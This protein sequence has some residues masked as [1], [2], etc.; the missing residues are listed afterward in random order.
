MSQSY[1]DPVPHRTLKNSLVSA[2]RR[3]TQPKRRSV[4][5]LEQRRLLAT[6]TVT[7]AAD[8]GTGSLRAAIDLAYNN[9]GADTINFANALGGQTIS[10]TTAGSDRFGYAALAVFDQQLTIDGQTSNGNVTIA[11]GAT[12]PLMRLITVYNA[13]T[14]SLTL[15]NLTLT[16][17]S[18]KG[19]DG[20]GNGGGG[21]GVG[22]AIWNSAPLT[23]QNSTISGN[24][25]KGGQGGKISSTDSQPALTG[26]GGG[27]GMTGDG[28]YERGGGPDGGFAGNYG[29][30]QAGQT[31]GFG[32]GG[33]GG[34]NVFG[35]TSAGPGGVG[36]FLG[37]AGGP[38]RAP[39]NLAPDGSSGGFG[40]GGSAGTPASRSSTGGFGGFGGGDGD[41]NV[42][43][44]FTTLT[45]YGGAGAGFGGAIFTYATNLTVEN[46]AIVNNSAAGGDKLAITGNYND[47]TPGDGMGGGIFNYGGNVTIQNSTFSGNRAS[48]G[49]GSANSASRGAGGG[50]IN[51]NG[52][53]TLTHV[54]L[55]SNV[56]EGVGTNSSNFSRDGDAIYNLG[57]GGSAVVNIRNSILSS[58]PSNIFAAGAFASVAT[59][60]GSVSHSA[61]GSF[62]TATNVTVAGLT[63]SAS[64]T[65]S[66]LGDYGGPTQSIR[67]TGTNPAINGGTSG[68]G[69]IVDQRGVARPQF[70]APDAGAVEQNPADIG[71]PVINTAGILWY[72]GPDAVGPNLRVYREAGGQP[73]EWI[74]G[75][76]AIRIGQAVDGTVLV[77]NANFDVFAINGSRTGTFVNY[78]LL[79]SAKSAGDTTYFLGPDG[80]LGNLNVYRW[81]T[82]GTL[83]FTAGGGTDIGLAQDSTVL[84]RNAARGVFS[85]PGSNANEFNGFAA[86]TPTVEATTSSTTFTAFVG[87]DG[88]GTDNNVYYWLDA[89]GPT[90]ANFAAARLGLSQGGTVLARKSD[91]TVWAATQ[92]NIGPFA[93]LNGVSGPANTSWF[94][95][96]EVSGND[97]FFYRWNATGSPTQNPGAA[98]RVGQATDGTIVVQNSFNSAF[99]VEGSLTG[100]F[101][102]YR[103]LSS[104]VA[105]G[106]VTWFIGPDTSAGN[107]IV[108]RWPLGESVANTGGGALRIGTGLNGG[109]VLQNAAGAV[110]TA[111][112]SATGA[113]S[114]YVTRASVTAGDGATW[115]LG[116]DSNATGTFIYRW[117]TG[118]S[119][120][121]ASGTGDTLGVLSDGRVWTRNAAKEVFLRLGSSN[122]LGTTW[123]QI[124]ESL[125]V[126]TTSDENDG[127]SD[128][129][130]GSGTSL[131]EAIAYAQN[132]GGSRTITFSLGSSPATITLNQIDAVASAFYIDAN[133]SITLQGPSGVAGVTLAVAPSVSMRHFLVSSGGS[134]TLNNLTLSGGRGVVSGGAILNGSGGT[135]TLNGV[136]LTG[137]SA[138]QVG[139]AITSDPTS[140]L[141]ISNSTFVGN[142]A[143]VG[144]AIRSQATN[145]VWTNATIVDN[146][147]FGGGGAVRIGPGHILRNSIIARNLT[148]GGQAA[149]VIPDSSGFSAASLS[150]IVT[151]S[152]GSGLI[153]ANGNQ[154]DRPV[155]EL[156]LGTLASNGGPTQ[157]VAPLPGSPAINAGISLSGL[158]VDQ[159]GVSRPQGSQPDIGA[160]ERAATGATLQ[161]RSF[162]YETRQAIVFDFN[163]DASVTFGRSSFTLTNRT[164][165][166]LISPTVGSLQWNDAG[167][168]AAL[169]V[170]NL[171]ADG[172]YRVTNG[173]STFDFFVLAGDANRDRAVNFDDL[174]LLAA[175]YNQTARTFS[176]GDFNYDGAVNFDDLLMLAARYNTGLSSAS[177]PPPPLVLPLGNDQ[178]DDGSDVLA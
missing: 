27:G 117:A 45:V 9:P 81:Q 98:V 162:E 113:F 138:Q 10:L 73:A 6:F 63:T 16:G 135:L 70:G 178:P 80:A 79:K 37:G 71:Q 124:V 174:L 24:V 21:A 75:G 68:L 69:V 32:G 5:S 85:V 77:Q 57:N 120:E 154:L 106:G 12:A 147:A 3:R 114:G 140:T 23:I 2:G 148:T 89:L 59:N 51:Y 19:G 87:P 7:S 8:S 42:E 44:N 151:P 158:T 29:T 150:N 128:S 97:R 125:V 146:T 105:G 101:T 15:R 26:G 54:T 1:A 62:T 126:T 64:L 119:P 157:T 165:G 96:P 132:L 83:T 95:G 90:Y 143:P 171:L 94:V 169:V 167:T 172:D 139:G 76:T 65:L 149:G 74:G 36:G 108:Y 13:A 144:A 43:G 4:D 34:G 177:M 39:Q 156:R 112:G 118:L 170:T 30:A 115:L 164:T 14:T 107:Q 67:P 176:Q 61:T 38:G 72:L 56:S 40:G 22:G 33:G 152:F 25:A 66:P 163:D 110:F 166:Q 122:G 11:R 130:V 35:N 88:S 31:G 92:S 100:A 17:G 121:F 161:N 175:N 129:I 102:S 133:S 18:I 111:L 78:Q 168:R 41:N 104:V 99:S 136:T 127:T 47:N 155:S 141:T 46:S 28:T 84:I 142:T 82:N 137:N 153:N 50:I 86:I 49:S 20:I 93:Q 55:A 103:S 60:G 159:R 58:Q 131:R 48:R 123:K 52:T 91:G 134:L 173:T 116:P 109:V 145:S 160:Y 53:L